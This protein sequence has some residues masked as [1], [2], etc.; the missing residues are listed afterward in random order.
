MTYLSDLVREVFYSFYMLNFFTI[1]LLYFYLITLTPLQG[2][3]LL[4]NEVLA[5]NTKVNY[6]GFW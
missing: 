2:Q 5:S 1:A 4:I 3:S 6:D